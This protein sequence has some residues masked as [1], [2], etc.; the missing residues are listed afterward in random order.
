MFFVNPVALG[1]YLET[2]KPEVGI[3]TQNYVSCARLVLKSKRTQP[4]DRRSC[5][6]KNGISIT[7]PK[8]TTVTSCVFFLINK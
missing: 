2:S 6:L 7:L 4:L 1:D 8:M 5:P 3:G